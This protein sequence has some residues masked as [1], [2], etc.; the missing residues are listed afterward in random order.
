MKKILPLALLLMVSSMMYAGRRANK[1]TDQW[2]Y[3]LECAGNGQQGTYLV[4]V[5]SYSK[6]QRVAYEQCSKNAVH[7]VIFKGFAGGQGCTAQ[8]PLAQNPGVEQE[9]AD[10]FKHFFDNGGEYMKYVQVKSPE[11][12]TVKIKSEYKVGVV[13]SVAKDQLR[14][15]LEQA[16]II[17][18][19]STGF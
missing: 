9:H 17:R 5:W 10:F 4:K 7:G 12:Q 2:R 11:R 19:L 16:G 8:R 18:G 13:V 3:E 14:K 1:L 6:N 15:A